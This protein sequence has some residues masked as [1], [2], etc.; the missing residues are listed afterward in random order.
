MNKAILVP[1]VVGVIGLGVGFA[2]GSAFEKS[3]QIS[4]ARMQSMNPEERRQFFQGNAIGAAG[5]GQMMMR[6]P[7][8]NSGFAGRG[9]MGFINGE[10]LSKDAQSLTVKLPDGGSKMVLFSTS[11]MIGKSSTGTVDDLMIGG[12]VMVNGETNSDGSVTARNI[13]VRN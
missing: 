13:Q 4:P 11:T 5:Q 8:G 7:G 2:G 3:K 9:G 6:G 10:V 1:V 12:N